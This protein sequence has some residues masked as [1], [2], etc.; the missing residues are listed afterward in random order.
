MGSSAE[1]AYSVPAI[2]VQA[3]INPRA[4]IAKFRISWS[5]FDSSGAIRHVLP[6]GISCDDAIIKCHGS[7]IPQPVRFGAMKALSGRPESCGSQRV[8]QAFGWGTW[9]RSQCHAIFL[10]TKEPRRLDG[11]AHQWTSPQVPGS[12]HGVKCGYGALAAPF[13]RELSAEMAG[14]ECFPHGIVG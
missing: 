10:F 11:L 4:S 5:T 14:L 7:G 3:E 13:G 1:W 2:T 8:W 9:I 12:G 6:Q